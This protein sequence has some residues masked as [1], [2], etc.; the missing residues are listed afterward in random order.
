MFAKC[1]RSFSLQF[2][3]LKSYSCSNSERVGRLS[4][5]SFLLFLY[6]AVFE[7]ELML[8][9]LDIM[10]GVLPPCSFE[11]EQQSFPFSGQHHEFAKHVTRPFDGGFPPFTTYRARRILGIT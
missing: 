11:A 2:F 6:L 10:V 5:H 4:I 9:L 7:F 3:N 8:R 1:E